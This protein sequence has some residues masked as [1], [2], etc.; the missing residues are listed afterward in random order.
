LSTPLEEILVAR[1]RDSGPMPFA[2]F[3]SLALYHPQHGYYTA[4]PAR[5]GWRGHFLTSPELDPGYGELWARGFADVWHRCGEPTSFE[6]IEIG[7][8]EGTFAAAVLGSVTGRFADAL[9]YRLVERSPAL[10]ER[11]EKA[12]RD[13]PRVEW[14][15][16]I[17][18]VA[19]VGHA[20]VF[21][22]EVLD[23]LPVHLVERT[24]DGL[25]EICVGLQDERLVFVDLEPSNP[26]LERFLERCGVEVP[27]GHRSEITLAAESFV[28]RVARMFEAGCAIFVDY[29]SDATDLVSRPRGSLLAYSQ[30]GTDEKV[31]D[32]VGSK[33]ITAH[34]NWTAVA[35]ACRRSGLEVTEPISQRAALESLGLHELHEH[36]RESHRLA[37]EEK[38]G[39][40]A[41]ASISRRQA[42]GALA[43]PGGLGGLLTLVAGRGLDLSG[44]P[45][46][47]RRGAGLTRPLS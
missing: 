2:A 47:K 32:Q 26:E 7:P 23:N 17:T 4:G 41:I 39:A 45:G 12:L 38:R 5:V 8:G 35:N 27:E 37:I 44:I 18:E 46:Q 21:A 1:I 22:N 15:P 31:L 14:S 25:R 10:R 16:S 42:L 13:F 20:V 36:L 9:T 11:Q 24:T 3:M 29:G 34:A 43:D 19:T 6:V 30:A 40:D 28:G 33:D